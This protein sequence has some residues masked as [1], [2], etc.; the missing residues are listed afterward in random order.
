MGSQT[1]FLDTKYR[2]VD[3]DIMRKLETLS[4]IV[5]PILE[6]V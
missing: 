5:N 1:L 6:G 2:L 3:Y 4:N